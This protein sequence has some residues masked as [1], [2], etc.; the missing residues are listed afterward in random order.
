MSGRAKDPKRRGEFGAHCFCHNRSFPSGRVLSR[1]RFYPTH[2]N[3][4]STFQIVRTSIHEK[5]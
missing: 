1:Q 2:H 5:M 4:H 3:F